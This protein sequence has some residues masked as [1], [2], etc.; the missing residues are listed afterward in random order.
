VKLPGSLRFFRSPEIMPT[1]ILHGAFFRNEIEARIDASFIGLKSVSG[2][3]CGVASDSLAR[4]ILG[5]DL[6]AS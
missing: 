1:Q 3:A 5:R 4:L 2:S 6:E